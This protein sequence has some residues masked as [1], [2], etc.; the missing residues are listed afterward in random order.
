[1]GYSN[2]PGVKANYIDGAFFNQPGSGQPRIV[3]MGVA[4]RGDSYKLF[5]V[6]N[7]NEA[8]REFGD[9]GEMIRR[10]YEAF[11]MGA[12]NVY[13]MRIG[14]TTSE[15]VV[16]DSNSGTLTLSTTQTGDDSGDRFSLFLTAYDP[17][18]GDEQN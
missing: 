9:R 2:L 12:D 5:R 18:T 7:Q 13:L 10:M 14:G 16:T 11:E 1:M 4:A 8:V 3:I 6:F 17:G 15:L